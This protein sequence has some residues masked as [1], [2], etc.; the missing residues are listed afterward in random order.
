MSWSFYSEKNWM[1]SSWTDSQVTFWCSCQ[2]ETFLKTAISSL[3]YK[4]S[5]IILIYILHY[6]IKSINK[7]HW[8][9]IKLNINWSLNSHV[10]ISLVDSS[11]LKC[12]VMLTG[13]WSQLFYRVQRLNLQ[14]LQER[15]TLKLK[16]LC[17]YKTLVIIYHSI[18]CNVPDGD[19]C[20]HCYKC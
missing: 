9:C 3:L 4:K 19:P 11:I 14:V 7:M 8:S 5:H 18:S 10:R 17:S 15:L 6:W 16:A 20:H 1:K 2:Q 12:H 13:K